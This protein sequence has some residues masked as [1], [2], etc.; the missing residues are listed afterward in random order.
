[1]C[2]KKIDT[3]VQLVTYFDIFERFG[4]VINIASPNFKAYNWRKAAKENLKQT[5]SWHYK[6]NCA[7]RMIL[8]Q[9][10]E[11]V[12]VRGEPQYRTDIGCGKS[13][14]KKEKRVSTIKPDLLHIGSSIK[15]EKLTMYAHY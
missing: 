9:E 1:M 8:T 6:F 10:K 12:F 11:N 4:T 13:V 2:K 14:L 7:K 3:V 15:K 5:S